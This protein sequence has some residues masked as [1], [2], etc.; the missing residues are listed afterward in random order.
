M[1]AAMA[2]RKLTL[3]ILPEVFAI[4]QLERDA[5]IPEWASRGRFTSTTRTAD[6]LSVVCL[7]SAVPAGIRAQH[8]W[9]AL[10]VHGPFDFSEVGVLAALAAPLA[11]AGISLFS[12]AT[13]DTDYVLVQ[14]RNL[15]A[16]LR[17]LSGAGHRLAPP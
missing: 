8:N 15:E 3:S 14:E 2:Q 17:A 10:K 9:R 7:A 12:L 6:E 11:E 5:Q 1:I 4:C 13:Y 16:A